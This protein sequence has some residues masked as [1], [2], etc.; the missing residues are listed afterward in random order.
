M[1]RDTEILQAL[2]ILRRGNHGD[3]DTSELFDSILR[4][5]RF[6]YVPVSLG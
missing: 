4:L 2:A 5:L 1:S 6:S 3:D